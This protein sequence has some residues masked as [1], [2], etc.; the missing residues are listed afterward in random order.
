MDNAKKNFTIVQY[1]QGKKSIIE[2]MVIG[3]EEVSLSVNGKVWL[4]FLCSPIDLRELAIGFLFNEEI[5]QS[6]SQISEIFIYPDKN[7]ID[8]WLTIDVEEPSRW[9]ITSGCVGGKTSVVGD[10]DKQQIEIKSLLSYDEIVKTSNQLFSMQGL[11]QEVRGVHAASISNSEGNIFISE[12]IGRHNAIDKV[13]GKF[14]L[15]NDK[16]PPIIIN[17]S[18]RVSSEMLQKCARIK[19]EIVISRTSPTSKSIDVA[20]K[21]GIT[22]I[23]YARGKKFNIYSHP[24]RIK[25]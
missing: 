22:L 7:L 20:I 6:I 15:S 12:D 24:E 8:V 14:L 1:F 21:A 13:I 17:T 9:I 3:E 23:G 11:Y 5:I 19:A 18:G 2:N 4:N 25:E 10:N 16:L